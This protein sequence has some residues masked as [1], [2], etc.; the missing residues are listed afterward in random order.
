MVLVTRRGPRGGRFGP[1]RGE[2]TVEWGPPSQSGGPVLDHL[3][4][5]MR[6]GSLELRNRIAMAPM[7]VEIVDGDGHVREPVIRYYEERARG[8]AGLL[9]TE[10]A[11]VA[12]PRGANSSH[13]I[14]L[15]DDVF[16][17][18]LRELTSRVQAHGAKIAAQLVHHGKAS[19][20]DVKEGREVLMP[21]E[22]TFHGSMD[23]GQVL[24]PEEIRL[25][26][27]AVGGAQPK[28]REATRA[29]L[30]Q[31]VDVFASAAE[32][33]KRAGF[34]AVELHAAHGYILS[35][36]LSPAWNLRD[37]EYG[38]PVENRARL[39]CEVLRAAKQ[40]AGAD[41][42][43]WCRLDAVEYRTPNGIVYE[44]AQR[45]AELAAEAGADAI[46]VSAYADA[47]SGAGFT[48]APLPHRECAYVD[49][50][51]G[52][53]Q[54]TGVPVIAVGRIEPEVGDRLVRD[55]KADVISLG[56]K[57]L[58]DP[59]LAKKLSEGR[60][61]D[62]RPCIYCYV[63]VAQA[64]FDKTVKC[65]VN[66]V[67][68]NE[69]AL[70]ELQRTPADTAKHVLVV[71]GGPAGMEAARV[72]AL[73]GHRVTL[74][75]KSRQLGGT[76]RF[77]ALVYEPNE[78]LLRW[79]E[80]QMRKLPVDVQLGVEATAERVHELD[81]DA[82]LVAT[83]ASRQAL[84]V[85]GAE[86]EHVFD[87]DD[88]RAL[89]TGEGSAE[90]SKKLSL[91]GRLAVLA[92]RA[93]GVTSDPAKLREASK[94]Y[95]P[96]GNRVVV[97]GGGLV[98]VEL[99]EFMARRGRQVTVLEESGWLATE[100]AHPRR[101]RVLEEVRQAGVCLETNA[102]VLEIGAEDVRFECRGGDGVPATQTV[103]AD[104][105]VVATGLVPNPGPAERLR[106][107]GIELVEI[108]DATG[109]GYIEGAIHDGFH[110][111]LAL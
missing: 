68:A 51:A 78:R 20:L 100:M 38:G 89:L 64:F 7:G 54:C 15:S 40:R 6:I 22:P 85:P 26:I 87:G 60:P 63:C 108:G 34:D 43:I 3:L 57:L 75:E 110:A 71:G 93:T 10:V 81:P 11:A 109:V 29:D 33:A 23:L 107:A 55:G 88:L 77:A 79:L 73:R 62:V 84:A 69:E 70:A 18:G 49:F 76:L 46:H 59:E 104:T 47:T 25:M 74:W 21:S 9:I 17:P 106:A 95:M 36:F 42:P 12:Y 58:A 39:L 24:T 19:R 50:A 65:A 96:V 86:R 52:I 44:D 35:E 8:G 5:P 67:T 13:Q 80:T 103:A 102:R 61:E 91:G 1:C 16:L 14:A 94:A 56:R 97:I 41:F 27:G 30:G 28:I 48:E 2:D 82:V 66:P 83:G 32:R 99:A 53:K 90:A 31:L 72:A 101:A 98:G 105:V 111:A 37:D 4:S 45:T 92:G